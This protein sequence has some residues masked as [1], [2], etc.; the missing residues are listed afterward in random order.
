[1]PHPPEGLS[2]IQAMPELGMS[3]LQPLGMFQPPESEFEMSPLDAGLSTGVLLQMFGGDMTQL[4]AILRQ[5]FNPS[6]QMPRGLGNMLGQPGAL[7]EMVTR[8]HGGYTRTGDGS[9]MKSAAVARDRFKGLMGFDPRSAANRVTLPDGTVVEET[10]TG[11]YV[12]VPKSVIT[13]PPN[14][15]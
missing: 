8:G 15:G 13:L 5:G 3:E 14:R 11:E 10:A 12:A 2:E 7:D 4:Q 9:I 6:P 1:M